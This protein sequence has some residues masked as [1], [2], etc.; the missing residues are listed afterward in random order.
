M[1]FHRHGVCVKNNLKHNICW[2]EINNPAKLIFVQ[3]QLPL[4]SRNNIPPEC[5]PLPEFPQFS[6]FYTIPCT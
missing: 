4:N 6:H 2:G 1:M 3:L 5:K